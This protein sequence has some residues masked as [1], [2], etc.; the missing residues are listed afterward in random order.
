MRVDNGS[1]LAQSSTLRRKSLVMLT[2]S[3]AVV[4]IEAAALR[5]MEATGLA[6]ACGE[7]DEGE[8]GAR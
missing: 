4:D 6:P 1:G 5:G 7:F 2:S 8:I 3:E